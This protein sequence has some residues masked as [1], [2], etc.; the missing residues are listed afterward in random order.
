M[1]FTFVFF[2]SA[3][4]LCR[5][6]F[7]QED[8]FQDKRILGIEFFA[9]PAIIYNSALIGY[10]VQKA[11]S[12]QAIYF[13]SRLGFSSFESVTFNV[14]LTQNF[15]LRNRTYYFPICLDILNSR[16]DR[17]YEEGYFPHQLKFSLM[18]GFGE[19]MITSKKYYFRSEFLVGGSLNFTSTKGD[20]LPYRLKFSDY[21]VDRYYPDQN[22]LY[23]VVCRL[24]LSFVRKLGIH[25]PNFN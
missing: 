11:R 1:K 5:A 16:R 6:S 7:S 22:P 8:N 21:K 9:L 12:E 15:Y 14:S 24:R 10:S 3:V 13:A 17:Y 4:L 20:V 23:Q 25:Q 19:K 2:I 18:S